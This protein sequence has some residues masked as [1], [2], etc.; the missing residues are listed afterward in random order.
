MKGN[1]I[2]NADMATMG[3]WLREGWNWWLSELAQLVPARLRTIASSHAPLALFRDGSI[4]MLHGKRGTKERPVPAN[5]ALP[6]SCSLIREIRLPKMGAKDL[7]SFVALEAARL[8][9]LGGGSLLVD[10]AVGGRSAPEGQMSVRVAAIRHDMAVAA[11]AA[12]QDAGIAPQR[13]GVIDGSVRGSLVFD[14]S[15]QLRSEGM[16]A[17][18]G[19][20]RFAWWSLVGL[21][22]LLNLGLIVWRDQQSVEQLREMTE[23]QMPAVAVYRAIAAR[24][25]HIEQVARST[26]A[27]RAQHDALG[28]LAAA[29]AALPD[30][31]WV[32]RYIWNGNSVR[33]AGYLRP[34]TDIVAAL[35][36]NGR[37]VNARA[38]TGD[39]QADILIGQP[40]DV[41]A[42]IR[43]RRK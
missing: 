32:Q 39:V 34:P 23:Q 13:I 29:S 6:A 10:A 37:F 4:E 43:A 42:D 24:S 8:F 12:A 19:Q 30:S 28:D 20:Q 17:D 33:L 1:S 22:F 21:A 35:G 41:T 27:R 16:L 38:S 9:P 25:A 14:F 26:S 18:A 31:A 7:H 5:L 11:I 40:F 15:S 3:G 36:Q 2:L